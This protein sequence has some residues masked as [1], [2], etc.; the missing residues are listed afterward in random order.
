MSER[1]TEE[2][3]PRREQRARA[4]GR[5]WQS[6]DLTLGAVLTLTGVLVR[7][8]AEGARHGLEDLFT[9]AL[10]Q[11]LGHRVREGAP[12]RRRDGDLDERAR[13]G[14]HAALVGIARATGS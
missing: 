11:R 4:E 2:P 14:A 5:V 3:T 8:G 13:L 9:H 6:R 7:F 12:Q 10:A 1:R